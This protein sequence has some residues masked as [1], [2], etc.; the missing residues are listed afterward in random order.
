MKESNGLF[1]LERT[2][3]VPV[4]SVSVWC[5]VFIRVLYGT[6]FFDDGTALRFGRGRCRFEI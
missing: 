3:I 6:R 5:S 1:D 2:F 4:R